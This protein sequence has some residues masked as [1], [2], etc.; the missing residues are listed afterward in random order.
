MAVKLGLDPQ[1]LLETVK[2]YNGACRVG[3]FDHTIMDDCH[4]EGITP[5]KT[6]WALPID[7]G[8]FYG[9]TV[10]PGVTF[11][12]LGL[13]TDETTAVRFQGK[14]SEN[15]FVAGEMMAGNV[16]GKG[17]AA[18]IGMAIGTAF[19]RA[20]G[21]SAAKAALHQKDKTSATT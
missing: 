13:K 6:H 10:R 9:Y 17:Y 2:I 20:A 5:E 1:A 3:T 18:G 4:T 11:T 19:G 16:L 8:P 15:L 14:P 7:T 12:Y 21:V